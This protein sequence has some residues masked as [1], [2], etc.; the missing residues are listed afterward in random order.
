MVGGMTAVLAIPAGVELMGT[1]EHALKV[2]SMGWFCLILFPITLLPTLMFVP[3]NRATTQMT[4]DWRAAIRL[5]VANETMWRLLLADLGAGLGTAVSGALYIFMATY[6]MQLPEHASIALLFY[7]LASFVAMPF[8]L[9]LAYRVGKDTAMKIALGYGVLINVLLIPLA[10]PGNVLVLWVFTIFYSFAFGAAP[11]L[12]RSMM[13]DLTDA[14]ELV[15]GL[16]R[17]GLFFCAV[18]HHQQTGSGCRGG[19]EFYHS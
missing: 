16:K 2:A 17:A 8:W 5:V 11:T 13:A 19:C 3:D 6:V 10:Q 7:F 15:T 1:G 9:R 12:L 18:D 14:D 4:V